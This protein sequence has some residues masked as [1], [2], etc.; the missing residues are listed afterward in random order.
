MRQAGAKCGVVAA[1]ALALAAA[2]AG[3]AGGRTWTVAQDG[4]GDF[5]V[6]QD[7]VDAAADGDVI[8][9]GP[10]HYTEFQSEWGW[11]Q[12]PDG[13]GKL[14][15]RVDGAKSLTFIGAGAEATVIGPLEFIN[16]RGQFGFLLTAGEGTIRIENLRLQNLNYRAVYALNSRV[17]TAGV[18]VERCLW[19]FLYT[20][21]VQSVDV[22]SCEF[23]R[24]PQVSGSEFAI[25]CRAPVAE[26]RDS[27]FH[28]YRGGIMLDRAG[29]TNVR[30]SA[31][32]FT[33]QNW[34]RNGVQFVFSAGGVVENCYFSN[35]LSYALVVDGAGIT[36]FRN[37]VIESCGGGIGMVGAQ[38]MTMHDVSISECANVGYIGVPCDMQ[39]VYNNYFFRRQTDDS[40]YFK[41]SDWF[42]YGPYY[43]DLRNNYWGTTDPEEISR[44]IYDG[45][46]NPNV[47]IY[48]LFEPMADSPVRTEARSW[49]EVKGLFRK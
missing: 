45:Y 16:G 12:D 18:V 11:G 21:S 35:L 20:G 8:E 5:T 30:V 24:S 17:E 38:H 43:V 31:C 41:T 46:D 22:A 47:W 37:N 26:I 44:W 34:G 32:R 1:V 14:Y 3:V 2:G 7:A 13:I 19:G 36:T 25:S 23:L 39:S 33:G 49:S 28:D 48:V 15:V 29:S 4:S 10:G 42:P 9:I 6:I 40:Y 27:I